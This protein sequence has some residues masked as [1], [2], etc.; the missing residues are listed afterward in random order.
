[1]ASDFASCKSIPVASGTFT[2]TLVA[3]GSQPA[4]GQCILILNYGSGVVTVARSGQNINGAAANQTLAAGSASAPTSLLVIS[5]GTNYVAQPFGSAAASGPVTLNH[6][7]ALSNV[8]MNNTDATLFTYTLPANTL[9]AGGCIDLS[10]MI[11]LNGT[12][13]GTAFKLFFGA[14]STTIWSG[15]T[16]YGIAAWFPADG[17]KI[18]ICN[19]SGSTGAQTWYVPH[20]GYNASGPFYQNS[21]GGFT[22]TSAIDTTS[23][24]VIKLTANDSNALANIT[25]NFWTVR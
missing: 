14:T 3:S 19:N 5:D 7:A 9:G 24:V 21:Q 10:A 4:S 11:T 8:T 13:N 25:P 17:G 22:V 16:T 23:P 6:Q 12:P 2:I 15:W 1:L 18:E 20:W